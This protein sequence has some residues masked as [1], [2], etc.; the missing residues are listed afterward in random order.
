MAPWYT[1][2]HHSFHGTHGSNR[3]SISGAGSTPSS[4]A[5]TPSFG[6]QSHHSSSLNLSS[7]TQTPADHEPLD[8]MDPLFNES[9][10]AAPTASSSG[11]VTPF[12]SGATTPYST[13]GGGYFPN[14]H[15]IPLEIILDNDQLVL[16]GA[17]GD[18]NPA[19]LSGSVVLTLTESTNIKELTMELR[20]KAKVQFNEGSGLV[21]YQEST[22]NQRRSEKSSSHPPR[23]LPRLVVP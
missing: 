15:Y 20:G 18:S 14:S 23:P 13:G 16:R 11:A 22:D 8:P 19:Y 10:A 5:L 9:S 21:V 6:N 17:G 2:G 7:G 4:P 12:S 1:G 3:G